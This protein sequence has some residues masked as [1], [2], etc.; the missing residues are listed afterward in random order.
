MPT[1]DRTTLATTPDGTRVVLARSEEL[2]AVLSVQR[3]GFGRIARDFG[4]EPSHLSPLVETLE[5]LQRLE[6]AGMVFFVALD[7]QGEIVGTVRGCINAEGA[8]EVGR[9]AVS[10]SSLRQGIATALMTALEEWFPQAKRFELFTGALAEG[11][12]SLY[13]RLGYEVFRTGGDE[14]PQLVWLEKPGPSA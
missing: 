12:L 11:P 6:Q 5:D 13:R 1:D 2:G 9:L 14:A 3:D 8:V 7:P 4:I 10:E